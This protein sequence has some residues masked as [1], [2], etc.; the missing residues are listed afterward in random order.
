M[1]ALVLGVMLSA[2]QV[3]WAQYN[4]YP[5]PSS[6]YP[7]QYVPP[8]PSS[9]YPQQYAP[10]PYVPAAPLE[11]SFRARADDRY[12]VTVDDQSCTTPCAIKLRPGAWVMQNAGWAFRMADCGVTP[13][14][15]KTGISP[16]ISAT[17]SP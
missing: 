7:Q 9:P 17:A 8:P 15:Q 14:A 6:P 10:P 1:R 5:P 12:R 4:P 13:Q 3:A 2:T 11:V 16:G